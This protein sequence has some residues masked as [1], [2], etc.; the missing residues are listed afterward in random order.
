[1]LMVFALLPATAVSAAPSQSL[2]LRY[3]DYFTFE[4]ASDVSVPDGTTAVEVEDT[5]I[6]AVGVT[7]S[8]VTVTV[9]G[10]EYSVSVAKAKVN[11]VLV[12]GQSNAMGTA[13]AL[14]GVSTITP[15]KGNG[16]WWNGSGLTDLKE[17]VDAQ[18]E[19]SP[20]KSVGFYPALAEE[21]YDLTG[22]KTVIIH[23]YKSGRAIQEWT[24]SD[25]ARISNK[26]K[27]CVDYVAAD[28]NFEI[29]HAAYYWLQGESNSARPTANDGVYHEYANPDE[30][31]DM[32]MPLHDAYIEALETSGVE[33]MG[34][35]LAVR[36]MSTLTSQYNNAICDY[37]GPRAAQQN[38]ANQNDD[39]L[40]A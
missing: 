25:I 5:T 16:Y 23:D 11:I 40:S 4:N 24:E 19:A 32:Y 36:S 26:V 34:G 29:S 39:L 14:Q 17:K 10:T 30:Y 31:E 13:G 18:V 9:D 27:A 15:E 7:D 6:H 20:N 37:D 33:A 38:M 28:D 12:D 3:G 21:W 1:M 8:D 22:E 2:E 35:I